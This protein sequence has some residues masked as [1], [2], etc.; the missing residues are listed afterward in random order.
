MRGVGA[1]TR[2]PVCVS[3]CDLRLLVLRSCSPLSHVRPCNGRT[4]GSCSTLDAEQQLPPG[5]PPLLGT[6]A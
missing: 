4:D 3:H 6:Q 5:E 2:V 1:R